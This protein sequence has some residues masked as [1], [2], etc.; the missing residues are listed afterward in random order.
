MKSTQY[1]NSSAPMASQLGCSRFGLGNVTMY[2]ITQIV[3]ITE[4][5]AIM[6]FGNFVFFIFQPLLSLF[7]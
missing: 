2:A 1:M 4:I 6:I 7:L 5:T 3:T